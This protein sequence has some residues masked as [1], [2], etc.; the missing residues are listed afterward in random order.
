MSAEAEP[1]WEVCWQGGPGHAPGCY[2]FS[3]RRAADDLRVDGSAATRADVTEALSGW[4]PGLSRFD[5]ISAR[6]ATA[7]PRTHHFLNEADVPRHLLLRLGQ[8]RENLPGD[9]DISDYLSCRASELNVTA[10]QPRDG[11]WPGT[12]S[13]HRVLVSACY[14]W[15]DPRQVLTTP[16]NPRWGQ[17]HYNVDRVEELTRRLLTSPDLPVTVATTFSEI[18][19]VLD[20][21][22]GPN[23]PAYLNSVN[24]NHRVHMARMTELP[25]IWARVNL[26]TFPPGAL[27]QVYRH[28][29]WQSA[30][31][32]AYPDARFTVTEPPRRKMRQQYGDPPRSTR[33]LRP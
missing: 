31:R 17:F 22:P 18:P 28:A 27:S 2:P 1:R 30:Y 7:W 11:N 19:I 10:P 24:G 5:W 8:L 29:D 14:A 16:R 4:H 33:S 32:Q 25:A 20:L 15:V 12:L 6:E 9:R 21:L 13:D 23:G 3:A 26:P